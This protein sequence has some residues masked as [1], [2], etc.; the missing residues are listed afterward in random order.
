MDLGWGFAVG[1][2]RGADAAGDGDHAGGVGRDVFDGGDGE[3]E[4]ERRRGVAFVVPLVEIGVGVVVADAARGQGADADDAA[5]DG[6]AEAVGV[7]QQRG[8]RRGRGL[9]LR[10]PEAGGDPESKDSGD[11]EAERVAKGERE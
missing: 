10:G 6:A 5:L 9:N 4:G 7:G 1:E 2:E 8:L 11:G 3:V